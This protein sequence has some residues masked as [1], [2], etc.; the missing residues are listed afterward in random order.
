VVIL[1]VAA[2]A[3]RRTGAT[4]RA[5][6]GALAPAIFFP[7][8]AAHVQGFLWR[9]LFRGSPALA[10]A[11]VLLAPAEFRRL[12]RQELCRLDEDEAER[13]GPGAPTESDVRT[14]RQALLGLLSALGIDPV[15]LAAGEA[16]QDVLAA[17]FCPL[18]AAEYRAGFVRCADCGV[19]LRPFA[20]PGPSVSPAPR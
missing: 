8:A 19:G 17:V 14:A 1:A 9:D 12:A 15:A 10:V 16:P 4:P 5:V 6:A 18:C 11:S 3:L 13:E 20:T 2:R 7:P